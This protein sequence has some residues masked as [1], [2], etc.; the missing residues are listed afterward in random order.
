MLSHFFILV[1]IDALY[2]Q[3][4]DLLLIISMRHVSPSIPSSVCFL[5][6]NVCFYQMVMISVEIK[7]TV[8]LYVKVDNIWNF[9]P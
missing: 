1:D 7:S 4:I 3:N 6:K 5:T 2:S 9:S 8:N